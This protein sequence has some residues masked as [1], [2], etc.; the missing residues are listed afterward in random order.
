MKKSLTHVAWVVDSDSA[1]IGHGR[2]EVGSIPANHSNMTK[3]TGASDVGFKRI[4]AQLRRWVE[5][6]RALI[7]ENA[8]E[9][10]EDCLSSLNRVT[11]RARIRAVDPSHAATFHWLFD[12][13]IVPFA[14][15]LKASSTR[16]NPIFWIQG[17]PGS[18]KSALMKFALEHP[19]TRALLDATEFGW[20]RI[21][22]FFHERGSYEQKSLLGML[23]E[24]LFQVLYKYTELFPVLEPVFKRLVQQQKTRS[25]AWD[26]DVVKECFFA[27]A[28]Q[29]ENKLRLCLFLDALDEHDGDNN[30]L[31]D[32][33]ERLVAEPNPSVMIRICVASRPWSIFKTRFSE[34]L[35]LEVHLHTH[36]DISDY[37]LSRLRD[38]LNPQE[39]KASSS[40]LE[41]LADRVAA[42]ALGV[43]I[44][45]RIVVDELYK[46]LQNGTPFPTLEEVVDDMPEE[47]KDLYS[48]TL[49]RVESAYLFEGLAM[50]Q[51]V[52]CSRSP[53]TLT[54]LISNID[55]S[56]QSGLV[57]YKS[58]VRNIPF[59]NKWKRRPRI[60]VAI[61]S[62]S[63]P[64]QGVIAM[65]RR[66][67]SRSGGLLEIAHGDASSP[68][69]IVQFL[70]QTVKEF[71]RTYSPSGL[72]APTGRSGYELLLHQAC[73][74]PREF[75]HPIRA[76]VLYYAKA[77]ESTTHRSS[78]QYL[79]Q[80]Q[81]R[82]FK[83]L[84]S[85]GP[86][87]TAI[88]GLEW[89]LLRSPEI[90]TLP[91]ETSHYRSTQVEII[92]KLYGNP[93]GINSSVTASNNLLLYMAV[94]ATL[95]L[96]IDEHL[97][98]VPPDIPVCQ[99]AAFAPNFVP[100]LSN[101]VQRMMDIL[102]INARYGP[103]PTLSDPADH[104]VLA[105]LLQNDL[106]S[107]PRGQVRVGIAKETLRVH[108]AA[109]GFCHTG[110]SFLEHCTLR[111]SPEMVRLL[112]AHG[113]SPNS[114]INPA[115]LWYLALF[116]HDREILD[117][118][119]EFGIDVP[120][121]IRAP[122]EYGE[123][124]VDSSNICCT[125]FLGELSLL[126]G[127][128]PSAAD[129]DSSP[130]GHIERQTSAPNMGPSRLERTQGG[131]PQEGWWDTSGPS[132]WLS[133]KRK[134]L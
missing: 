24:L 100:E 58:S 126:I 73:V 97:R 107:G 115:R 127:M 38:S 91:L 44:W 5:D 33:V 95:L 10:L 32:L 96:F 77:F 122:F 65:V 16:S 8:S 27:I 23:Q 28:R 19:K 124:E 101:P 9:I 134:S 89:W 39:Q 62:D 131:E 49:E 123:Y 15:W 109:K 111:E 55:I 47:L 37:S 53:P 56:L 75:V 42:K 90:A 78:R 120:S 64:P 68:D 72:T 34:Y 118:F 99:L 132:K 60:K 29:Q 110:I 102:V 85:I 57:P 4:S 82:R 59:D 22:F 108:P 2:E 106:R 61:Q 86:G 69:S 35:G 7:P 129:I 6:L 26:L 70:H 133:E 50:L 40:Q 67:A 1:K 12:E 114:W 84:P 119:T 30:E 83:Y 51:V 25:P 14:Q 125:R 71:A 36:Q 80:L 63:E 76:D 121:M 130:Q 105:A 21:G 98:N 17:K 112:L 11:M 43:F 3:F 92:R 117:T 81:E 41:S 52:L 31:V 104:V 103:L 113:A 46:G 87:S 18:G 48:C 116:R 74:D 45:V 13:T 94:G 128:M 88:T 20:T 79:I 54:Q 93:N 66:L